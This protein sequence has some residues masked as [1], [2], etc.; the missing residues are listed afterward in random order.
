M[1]KLSPEQT[2]EKNAHVSENLKNQVDTIFR[3]INENGIKT[4][5]RYR[6]DEY[7]FCDFLAEN[8]KL[9][10]LKNVSARHIYA[11]AARLEEFDHKPSYIPHRAF[12]YPLV[13]YPLRKQKQA[14]FKS[15][16]AS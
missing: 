14:A 9:K 8:H 5:Y 10:N 3:R 16:T 13:S 2:D 11:Y 15:G 7:R 4:R 1:S 6:A 12:R